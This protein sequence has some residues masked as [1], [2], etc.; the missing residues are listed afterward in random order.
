MHD[1]T[2]WA[3]RASHMSLVL[4]EQ[5]GKTERSR[6][7]MQ[8]PDDRGC[9]T[10]CAA[11]GN[12]DLYAFL[13]DSNT[14]PVPDPRSTAQPFGVHGPS[15]VYDQTQFEWHDDFWQGPPLSGAVIYELHVGTFTPEGTL[16]SAIERLPYLAD[17]GI[18]HVELMP[19]NAF[20]GD[21]G[22]GYDG[23]TLFA[24]QQTY[25][26]PDALKRFTNACHQ[27]HLAVLIDVV[28]NHFGP[29]GNYTAQFA[30]Y[31]TDRHSTPWGQAINF[32]A[33]GSDQVRRFFCDNALMWMRDFHADGLRLDAVHEFND[34][35]ATHFLE[36][37]ARE[38]DVVSATLSRRLILI[39]ESDLNNPHLVTSQE[40][41]G[42]GLDAQWSD[43]FHHA[44][45]TVLSEQPSG[46]GYYDD[47]GRMADLA[48][49]LKHAFVYDGRYSKYRQRSHGRP[50]TGLSAHHF[51]VF[52]QNHDQVGNRAVGDRIVEIAGLPLAKV[53]VALVLLSP[54][55]PMLF[56]GE[57]FAASSPFQYFAHHDDEELA[58]AVSAGRKKEFAAFGWDESTIPDPENRDTFQNSKLNWSEID[59]GEHAEMLAWVKELIQLRRH[60][61]SLNDGD[62][63]AEEV[64]FDEGKRWLTMRRGGVDLLLNIGKDAVSL[65]NES[66]L[67]LRLASSPGVHVSDSE[68]RLPA[69]TVAILAR[70]AQ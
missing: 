11:A 47:F 48:K 12:G 28:Y 42:M 9:W 1:F 52:L 62:L 31:L 16:D 23:V 17:L 15:A 58:K 27:H 34:R 69:G 33:E 35:S 51:V 60:T 19:L 50:V 41:G 56:Q 44:L 68:V 59:Q 37:L 14:T 66:G 46:M 22:W 24:V 45:F 2:V 32:E 55:I 5:D 53:G 8:G 21:F 26:G 54:F 30:P 7:P 3:P 40:A 63:Q 61:G 57:E 13:I 29:V 38:V 20:P 6:Q 64:R 43:D 39:A 18:T 65:P 67:P 10:L 4:F 49:V 36:Q 25:G 70:S